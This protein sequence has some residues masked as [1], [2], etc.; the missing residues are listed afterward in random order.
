V[1]VHEV[2][3]K[4]TGSVVRCSLDA[5]G[6]DRWTEI[7]AWML[8]P[9]GCP[10]GEVVISAAV[11][12]IALVA[13]AE[14]LR[15]IRAKPAAM[16]GAPGRPW[17]ILSAETTR[18]E[19]HDERNEDFPTL[20]SPPGSGRSVLG[21]LSECGVADTGLAGP[22]GLGATD[23]DRPARKSAARPRRPDRRA[24]PEG[25]QR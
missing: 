16:D 1:T 8:D 2:I 23:R 15:L 21:R 14:L 10:S 4:V 13:L 19:G 22:A 7:P 24:D 20:P 18:G 17:P 6:T 3:E 11:D 25:G 5:S 12:V 9:V